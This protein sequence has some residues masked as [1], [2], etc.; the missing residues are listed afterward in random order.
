MKRIFILILFFGTILNAEQFF[1]ALQIPKFDK[2]KA[3]LGKE[4]YFDTR[5]SNDANRSCDSCHNMYL[6]HSGTTMQHLPENP[7]TVL[8]AVNNFRFYKDGRS[9][10]IY[11]Q[12]KQSLLSK[13]ELNSTKEIILDAVSKN[14][15]ISAKFALLYKDGVNFENIIDAIVN[16]EKSLVTPN[17]KFDKFLNGD[18]NALNQIQKKG[19]EKFIDFGC[20]FCHNG[21]N[22]G[23]NS[24]AYYNAK[25]YKVPTLRNIEITA[26]YFFDGSESKLKNAIITMAQVNLQKIISDEDAND[27]E[28][29]LKSL[30]SDILDI[31]EK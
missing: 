24:Y 26:P 31:D 2:S 12:V 13:D 4:L 10:D 7:P 25:L 16:Y 8:N 18:K 30:T 15:K 17:S 19:Y 22:L 20:V 14:E 11:D 27:I 3:L 28:Q 23:S 9:G 1:S 21:E 29:F 6:N 5:L